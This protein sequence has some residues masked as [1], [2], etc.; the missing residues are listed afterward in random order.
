M[1]RLY[2]R[3]LDPR[4]P[5]FLDDTV[6][7]HE[8]A[9]LGKPP[10][11]YK[12]IEENFE[13]LAAKEPDAT[14]ERLQELEIEARK[15]TRQPVLFFDYV[16]SVDKSTSLLHTA[17]ESAALQAD[18]TGSHDQ[19]SEYR[20]LAG[21]VEDAITD[22]NQAALE[23][24]QDQAGYSRTGYH[25][26]KPRDEHGRLIAGH[27]T[28]KF[29]DAHEW[30]IASFLQRTSR[31]GDPQIH[32]HNP[33][34]NRV[35]CDDGVWR[36]LDS[37]GLYRARAA[38]SAI[39]GRV[40]D[41][42]MSSIL[43]VAYEQRPG[44]KGRELR[45]FPR[46]VLDLYST[47]RAVVT[48]GVAEL[49]AAYE[50]K[51]QRPPD[52]RALWAMA[53]Y[54]AL[55]SRKQ[56]PHLIDTPNRTEML[57][58]WERQMQDA[59]LGALADIPSRV[60]GTRR[61]TERG[62]EG[63]A[64]EEISEI[65]NAAI[66]DL[67]S[68]QAT[69]SRSHLLAAID[70]HLPGWLGG[71]NAGMVRRVLNDLTDQA[72]TGDYGI[73]DLEAPEEVPV[74]AQLRRDDGRSIYRPHEPGIYTT[75]V[76]LEAEQALLDAAEPP[77]PGSRPSTG[78]PAAPPRVPTGQ[79]PAPE[80]AVQAPSVPLEAVAEAFGTTPAVIAALPGRVR[81][82]AADPQPARDTADDRLYDGLRPDQ[83]GAVAGIMTSGRFIDVLVGPAGSGKS[84]A[85]GQ[86]AGLWEQ[87]AHGRVIG[88]AAAENAAR[89]LAATG[90]GTVYNIARLLK[91][92]DSNPNVLF[93]GDLLIV[94][95]ASMV[96]TADLAALHDITRKSGAKMV[97]VGDPQQLPAV[98]AGGILGMLARRHGHFELTEVV[99]MQKLWEQAASLRLRDGDPDVL[100]D[101]DRHGRLAQGSFEEMSEA[102]YRGWLGDHLSGMNSLLI[103]ATNENAADLSAR[104][105]ADLVELGQVD[106]EY[107]IRLADGNHAGCG[108]LIQARQND[109]RIRTGN[110][111][112]ANRDMLR[113]EEIQY[114]GRRGG[115]PSGARVRL[116][117]PPDPET[118][119]GR[120]SDPFRVPAAYLRRHAVLGYAST[121][122]SAQGRTVDTVHS[123]IVEGM[124]RAYAY[125]ALTRARIA[126]YAYVATE[127]AFPD[128][129]QQGLADETKGQEQAADLTPGSKPAPAL[130]KIRD[131]SGAAAADDPESWGP[132]ADRFTNLA[133]ALTRDSGDTTALDTRADQAEHAVH[134]A[135]LGSIWVQEVAEECATRCDR[136]LNR[137]LT[138][139]QYE[140]YATEDARTTLARL[141]RAAEL[142]GRDPEE[143][144]AEAVGMFDLDNDEQRGKA[145]DISRTLHWRIKEQIFEG[146]T[147]E[148][149][150]PRMSFT[151]RTPRLSD[152]E[153]DAW[154]H[155]LA[156]RID[157]RVT[158]LGER[159]ADRPPRWALDRLGEPPVDPDG[160]DE[161]IRDAGTVAAYREQ[162][163]W[164]HETRPIGTEPE[165]DPDA[166][167]AWKA[168]SSALGTD[169]VLE[170]VQA[171]PDRDLHARRAR[172]DRELQW[173]PP[174]VAGD[175]RTSAIAL[176]EHQTEA[177]LARARAAAGT[178]SESDRIAAEK[179]A[180]AYDRFAATLQA[181]VDLLTEIDAQR[182]RWHA[183]TTAAREAAEL[184]TAELKRRYPDRDLPSYR[185]PHQ[186]GPEQDTDDLDSVDQRTADD[187]NRAAEQAAT[188]R[189][190]IDA[191]LRRRAEDRARRTRSPRPRWPHHPAH[192]R[193]GPHRDGPE[194]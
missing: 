170:E 146:E 183:E 158:E 160:F 31:N 9:R 10:R 132:E 77:V 90:V 28:G 14:P 191:R 130:E 178:I 47:R 86:L 39:G 53:Q 131:Q 149:R 15:I 127:R 23:Y 150:D 153:H 142:A 38:A 78:W 101:Y 5:H 106:D 11:T 82:N 173:S 164:S 88:V 105:R 74:P 64:E 93:P 97:L 122:H 54:V 27:T 49:A 6:P 186:A 113:V 75:A 107:V 102:A 37:R 98:G 66:A 42:R 3:L 30:V 126:N 44:L 70:A 136:I 159:A 91:Q 123:I 119:A 155:R 194:R 55:T 87:H 45:G 92:A 144:L 180:S 189:Q 1:R 156:A 157:Q 172:W 48:K 138:P 50:E 22:A 2:G 121:T 24:L 111:W 79:E 192:R 100:L 69:W 168:A 35:P 68:R 104:A 116:Q 115:N 135:N 17:L 151:E 56:K 134:L 133:D 140:R 177:A 60:I 148:P 33:I 63:L 95:E 72:L 94:D 161:W 58:A 166:R 179:R 65:L 162:Y 71:L 13:E 84:L 187:I 182:A 16:F 124:T 174:H 26:A 19:A 108:D 109:R 114:N 51:H 139:G 103:T 73:V 181:R 80:P 190:I 29:T 118:G 76:H 83:A 52:A 81:P 46:K 175:L 193:S 137:L 20:R 99:R 41:E 141:V 85:M 40:L 129:P 167:Y 25:G 61:R 169:P 12:S 110:R 36:T 143:L 34:V 152:P 67:Q 7:E 32:I 163:A 147:P 18:E 21:L 8:M 112:I 43:D 185:D 59:E 128:R 117:L 171:A 89:E 184:A 120:W 125:V 96:T 165:N 62:L 176:R 57:A 188:A 154:L 145:K 4:S